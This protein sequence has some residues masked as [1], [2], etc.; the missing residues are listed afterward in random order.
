MTQAPAATVGQVE[1]DR[2]VFVTGIAALDNG[3]RDASSTLRSATE[4]CSSTWRT[5]EHLNITQTEAQKPFEP[6]SSSDPRTR[7][8][9]SP[10]EVLARKKQAQSPH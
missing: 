8:D 2:N 5:P 3:H 10:T 4:Q 9:S 7:E 1:T 6:R